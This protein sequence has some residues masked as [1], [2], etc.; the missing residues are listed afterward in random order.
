MVEEGSAL[1]RAQWGPAVAPEPELA[2]EASQTPVDSQAWAPQG[3]AGW[4]KEAP[5]PGSSG[6]PVVA[7]EPELAEE[8]SQ[9]PCGLRDLG[10]SG[11]GRLEQGSARPRARGG[12]AGAPEPELA[13]EASPVPCRLPG[14]GRLE[15][16]S[17]RPGP[18]GDPAG[19]PEPELAEEASQAWWTPR[20]EPFTVWQDDGRE[21]LPQGPVGA[22]L[23]PLN[24]NW[25][26][27]PPRPG[28][29]RGLSPSGYGRL[30]E[31]N[32]RPR[33][34]WGPAGAPEPDLAG[35]ASPGPVDSQVWAPQNTAGWSKGAPAQGP[36][37][38]RLAPL[39]PNWQGKPP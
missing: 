39:K 5:A 30:E 16:G 2:G 36:V 34:R 33:A 8:V 14:Y 9:G 29:I 24:L 31:G 12:P 13:G 10:P 3:T 23:G 26:G 20:S 7:P 4:R 25:Q 38:A 28:G 27:K 15:Q 19:A 37:G 11:Y 17:T 1:P 21:R 22:Q 18:G 32:T 35:E 6:G